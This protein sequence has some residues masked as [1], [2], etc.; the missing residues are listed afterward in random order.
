MSQP[1]KIDR[2]RYD[3]MVAQTEQ[4][5]RT[6][7]G[8]QPRADGHPDAGR[9]L[10][11]I[12]GRMAALVSDRLN[13]VPEKNFLTFLNLIGTQLLPPQPAKVPLT[14]TLAEGSPV[15]ALVPAQTQVAAPPAEGEDEEVVFETTREILV[16]TAQ[17]KAVY[18]RQ[19]DADRYSDRTSFATT[20][21]T[22]DQ[23]AFPVFA[24]DRPI[25]HRLYLACDLF[26]L[27]GTKA[28]ALTINS[29]DAIALSKLPLRWAYWD[30]AVWKTAIGIVSGLAIA[31]EANQPRIRVAPG[32]AIDGSGRLIQVASEQIVELEA[33]RSQTV[34]VVISADPANPN[35]IVIADAAV[36]SHPTEQ[37]IRLARLTIDAQGKIKPAISARRNSEGTAATSP[38]TNRAWQVTLNLP[39]IQPHSLD[40]T[41]AAWLQIE[42]QGTLS[43]DQRPLPRLDRITATAN[44]NPRDLAP[45]LCLFNAVPIDLSKD[46]YPFGEQP[47]FNDTFYIASDTVFARAGA[48]VTLDVTVSNLEVNKTGGADLAWEVWNGSRWERVVPRDAT[49]QFTEFG[50]K[51]TITFTL[52]ATTAPTIVNNETHYWARG[53]LV[54]GN[55]GS[56]ATY[57]QRLDSNGRP[58]LVNNNP[59]Y[60]LV[61]ESFKPPVIES[62]RLAYSHQLTQAITTYRSFNDFDYQDPIINLTAPDSSFQPF[63]PSIDLHPALYLGFDRPFANRAIALYLQVAL[64][65]PGDVAEAVRQYPPDA[66]PPQII[67]EYA[68]PSGWT[69]LGVLDETNAFAERG[70]I[71]FIGPNNF[72]LRSLFGQSLYWLRSRWDGGDFLLPP[73]VHRVLTNT[74]WG[75]QSLTLTDELLG[76]SD[77]SPHQTF[78]T[79]RSPILFAQQLEVQE[80]G[81][82]DASW[83][84]WQEVSDF[85]N[86]GMHDRHYVLDRL[87]G[88]VS[89]GDGQFGKV[90]PAGRNN[91]RFARYQTGGGQH[92]NQP[93]GAV[94]QL[95]T[96]VPYVDRVT[97][98]EAASGGADQEPLLQAQQ[99]GTTVLRHQNRAVTVQDL[100]DLAYAASPDVSSARAI[101]P[102]FDP[103]GLQWLPIYPLPLERP[104]E[105]RVNVSTP[106]ALEIRLYG[107]G[108]AAPYVQQSLRQGQTFSYTVTAEQFQIG[109]QW[110]L[111]L[112]NPTANSVQGQVSITYPTGSIN[113][114]EFTAPPSTPTPATSRDLQDNP[115]GDVPDAGQ[116]DLIILPRSSARQPT[117][118]LAL[119]D[120]VRSYIRDRTAATLTCRVTEPDWVEVTVTAQ[121]VPLAPESADAVR[122]AAIHAL[123]RFLHPID[124]GANAGWELGRRV[125]KSD[126]YSLL[127]SLE[128]VDH[129]HSLSIRNIPSLANLSEASPDPGEDDPTI[130]RLASDRLDRFMIYSGIHQ[131]TLK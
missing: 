65:L 30:G 120:R 44:L 40:G 63:T 1:P 96:T 34:L 9:A 51:N 100:E 86:S 83:V 67:W 66:T 3:E 118:S 12:F 37:F 87:T 77:G 103:I 29:P 84:R 20:S 113:A 33:H 59:I 22:S 23:P 119:L 82:P 64:P 75:S 17:L 116:V 46:F 21:D 57:Q 25:P 27:P 11:R 74:T 10:F 128:G 72:A 104:G 32:T 81:Q 48:T 42:L 36:E 53:R 2:R 107:G 50:K 76:S 70:L 56:A 73:R 121:I 13:R 62:L 31:I 7:A 99:R 39:E 4:L 93:I 123:T 28:I 114:A 68:S 97:N 98:L 112:L 105:I 8:W 109:Q 41:T 85:Y 38:S 88:A 117:P 102:H 95:K 94:N 125:Y 78:R 122:V 79:A 6:Y 115:Y 16:T 45:D 43:A 58:V 18:V 35:P 91:L 106:A 49:K 52:P 26:T 61:P 19:P 126:L 110:Q 129:I 69:S 127:E 47:R 55:Y 130:T 90:P 89:F 131:I 5:A 124:G 111:T 15:D 108:Q 92:G 24:G 80:T 54:R 60:D 14:F 71:R 101:A